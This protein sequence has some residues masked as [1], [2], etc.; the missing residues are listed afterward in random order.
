[1]NTRPSLRV[2]LLRNAH[3]DAERELVD[4][5]MPAVPRVGDMVNHHDRTER[6]V[7]AYWNADPRIPADVVLFVEPDTDRPRHVS[8][9]TW[10]RLPEVIAYAERRDISFDGAVRELVN[11][12]LSHL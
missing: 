10:T 1:M 6:V 2:R 5:E 11:S 8:T 4:L 3:P 12:G 9:A 7:E